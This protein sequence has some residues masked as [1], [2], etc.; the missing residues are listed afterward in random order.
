M[1]ISGIYHWVYNISGGL[2]WYIGPG[3][4]VGLYEDRNNSNNDGI[5]LAV[6]GQL[7][8]EYDFNNLGAPILLGID[9]RPMWGFSGGTQGVGYGGALSLKFTF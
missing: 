5:T 4:Q 7:G 9:T 1:R 3:A 6:G 8:L 2:N